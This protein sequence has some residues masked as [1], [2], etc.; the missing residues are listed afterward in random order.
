M[1]QHMSLLEQ[2]VKIEVNSAAPPSL[3]ISETSDRLMIMPKAGEGISLLQPVQ[4]LTISDR[5]CETLTI[6]DGHDQ[7]LII[8]A[9]ESKIFGEPYYG[10]EDTAFHYFSWQHQNG[11]RWKAQRFD[12][13]TSG[14]S[15]LFGDNP[16]PQTLAEFQLL[17][18]A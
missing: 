9:I 6:R 17:P 14:I 1:E 7:T 10:I 12:A 5:I 13:A 8:S 16:Q 4:T 11:T 18:F 2:T 3:V 15:T